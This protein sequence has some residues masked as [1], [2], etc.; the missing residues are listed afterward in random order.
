MGCNTLKIETM[1]KEKDEPKYDPGATRLLKI[2]ILES[3]YLIW[4]LCCER[5]NHKKVH[6]DK[7]IEAAWPH[8]I[9]GR[10]S[11]DKTT[12]TKVL[13]TTHKTSKK[14][15]GQSPVQ[16]APQPPRRLDNSKRGFLVG[17]KSFRT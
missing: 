2:I 12:A 8:V 16:E 17:R 11:E 9:N 14:H 1:Q 5:T 7:E 4:T 10:L 13:R 3:A 6:T 15:M